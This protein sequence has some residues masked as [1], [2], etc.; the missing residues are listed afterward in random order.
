MLD[1]LKL[2]KIKFE[3]SSIIFENLEHGHECY[4][5]HK[6]HSAWLIYSYIMHTVFF[7]LN[8]T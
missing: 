6:Y 3:L 4:F 8:K 1:V 2:I 7:L 5:V